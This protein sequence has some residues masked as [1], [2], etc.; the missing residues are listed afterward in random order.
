MD[1]TLDW[2]SSKLFETYTAAAN[3]LEYVKTADPSVI[4]EFGLVSAFAVLVAVAYSKRRRRGSG[5]MT[6]QRI[7]KTRFSDAIT[8]AIEDGLA[9]GWWKEKDALRMYRKCTYKLDLPDLKPKSLISRKL[10][11]FKVQLLKVAIK[12]RTNGGPSHVKPSPIPEPSNIV[13]L[14]P[15]VM[16]K[17]KR[18]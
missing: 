10:H 9:K 15:V 17:K 12:A 4:T 8:T 6:D 18:A 16:R 3:I 5:K 1:L 2:V 7:F 13:V 11:P 14:K